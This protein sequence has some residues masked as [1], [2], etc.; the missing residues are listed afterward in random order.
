MNTIQPREASTNHNHNSSHDMTE[1]LSSEP[2]STHQN[3]ESGTEHRPFYSKTERRSGGCMQR[4]NEF[5]GPARP[6]PWLW[7]KFAVGYVYRCMKKAKG[8]D[9]QD[10]Y[11]PHHLVLLRRGRTSLCSCYPGQIQS[12]IQCWYWRYVQPLPRQNWAD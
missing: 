4:W 6:D 12:G 2:P 7:Q 1:F 11:R 5:W 3:Q 8:T 10:H 9:G